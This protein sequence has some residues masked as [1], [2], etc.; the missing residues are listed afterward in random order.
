MPETSNNAFI[1]F[2]DDRYGRIFPDWGPTPAQW[3]MIRHDRD[4]LVMSRKE[5]ARFHKKVGDMFTMTSTQV[6]RAD[7]GSN[8]TL[9]VIAIGEDVP[10]LTGGYVMGN[11]D[12][13]DQAVPRDNQGKTNEVDLQIFDPAQ[14]D[15]I[16]AR[17]DRLFA[18]SS[19]PTQSWTE[20]MAFNPSNNFGGLDMSGLA[21]D[22]ALVGL[23]MILFL[24]ANVI[25]Q[26]VRERLAEFAVL[27][28]MGFSDP[29][30]VGLV[31]LEAAVP[32]VV[33]AAAGLGLA[34]WLTGQIPKLFPPGFG[35]PMP[36]MS[37]AVILSAMLSA[38]RLRPPVRRYRPSGSSESISPPLCRGADDLAPANLGRLVAQLQEYETAR[39]AVAGGGDRNGVGDRR[40]AIHAVPD[41]RIAPGHREHR[42]SRSCPGSD[43]VCEL[44]RR[45]QRAA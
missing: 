39:Q 31:V 26:S 2:L 27:K 42:R 28:S 40:A 44:G 8:W 22:I 38:L 30:L 43:A 25:A 41:R 29:V 36:T 33:G 16:A 3:D 10:V 23:I 24:T 37:L 19:S 4:G 45:Q 9:K 7:G 32:C 15:A 18:N 13:F 12:F 6:P 1:A 21:Q 17:I 35:F 34:D 20:K 5:A 14:A 11:Y